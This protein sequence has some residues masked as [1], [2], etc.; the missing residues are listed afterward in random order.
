MPWHG[1]Y[2]KIACTSVARWRFGHNTTKF[3]QQIDYLKV[4]FFHRKMCL[5]SLHK[6][7]KYELV[8]MLHSKIMAKISD[9]TRWLKMNKLRVACLF[10]IFLRMCA[11]LK[12]TFHR[13]FVADSPSYRTIKKNFQK[14]LLLSCAFRLTDVTWWRSRSAM[15]LTFVPNFFSMLSFCIKIR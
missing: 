4:L 15:T 1:T 13:H 6:L 5:Y 7:W 14:G 11:I 8:W 10:F 12:K 3:S 9:V 2:L